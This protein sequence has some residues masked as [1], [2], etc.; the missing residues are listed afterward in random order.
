L[1]IRVTL[2]DWENGVKAS[3]SPP[4]GGAVRICAEL[5]GTGRQAY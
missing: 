5:D 2:Q 1:L 4:V 3:S